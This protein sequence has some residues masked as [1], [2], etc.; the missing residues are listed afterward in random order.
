MKAYDV[1]NQHL[2]AVEAGDREK[3]T[4]S[5]QTIIR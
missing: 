2:R 3:P 4:R 1:V 5:S